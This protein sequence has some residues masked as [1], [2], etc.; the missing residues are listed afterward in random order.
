MVY[1]P[2]GSYLEFPLQEKEPREFPKY[3]GIPGNPRE[4]KGIAEIHGCGWNIELKPWMSIIMQSYSLEMLTP[5]PLERAL[6]LSC[7][8]PHLSVEFSAISAS[9]WLL[10][11]ALALM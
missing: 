5:I 3:P 8:L 9:K 6:R 10:R 4:S 1:V 2:E 7:L 11:A